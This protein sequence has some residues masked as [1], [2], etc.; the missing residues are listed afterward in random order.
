MPLCLHS[1]TAPNQIKC[2]ACGSLLAPQYDNYFTALGLT[3][4]Y[5]L[6]P[7]QLD[8][9]LYERIRQ[10]H[11][12]H[13]TRNSNEQQLAIAHSSYLN[14]AYRTL[15]SNIERLGYLL[16]LYGYDIE[17]SQAQVSSEFLMQAMEWRQDLAQAQTAEDVKH[18]ISD[19]AVLKQTYYSSCTQHDMSGDKKALFGVY[20]ELKFAERF[21]QELQKEL[22]KYDEEP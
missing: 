9:A 4:Q 12:D 19:L 21:G 17:N 18:L 1:A 10:L 16:Q 22:E 20:L 3:M 2:V 15:R 14:Q 6:D 13:Y 8:L 11:P 5:P 7:A